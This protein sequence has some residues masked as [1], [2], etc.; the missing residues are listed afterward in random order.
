MNDQYYHSEYSVV[1]TSTPSTDSDSVRGDNN[2]DKWEVHGNILYVLPA[3]LIQVEP[4]EDIPITGFRYVPDC[5]FETQLT[6]NT[7][8]S[9]EARQR[10][11][12]SKK[13]LQSSRISQRV[14]YK[15]RKRDPPK[16]Y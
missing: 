14:L 12:R 15:P 8:I 1:P 5:V 2:G 10:K 3:S 7:I 9:K 16:E 4:L 6:E 13:S 11:H